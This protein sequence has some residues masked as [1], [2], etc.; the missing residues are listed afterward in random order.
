MAKRPRKMVKLPDLGE[1][2]VAFVGKLTHPEQGSPLACIGGILHR[3]CLV[4]LDR[5][6][7]SGALE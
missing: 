1:M 6:I 3:Q 4:E 2:C 5:L 7:S